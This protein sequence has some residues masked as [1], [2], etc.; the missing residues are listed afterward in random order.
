MHIDTF[1][2][3]EGTVIPSTVSVVDVLGYY[4]PNDG[5]GG[6]YTEHA[7]E[8]SHT[9]KFQADDLRWF[10]L[11]PD[12][13]FR[14]EQFG[15]KGDGTTDDTAAI[16]A[17]LDAVDMIT[18]G[19]RTY[20]I[21]EALEVSIGQSIVGQGPDITRVKRLTYDL[22]AS[23]PHHGF[24]CN[25]DNITLRGFTYDGNR[26]GDGGVA[27][28]RC[29]AIVIQG[30]D[31]L[32]ED[33]WCE[34]ATGYGQWAASET[35]PVSGAHIRCRVWNANVA[36]EQTG[37]DEISIIDCEG[38]VAPRDGGSEI[39]FG[40]DALVHPYG[41]I[42]SLTVARFKGTG[43]TTGFAPLCNT[44]DLLHISLINCDFDMTGAGN[45]VNCVAEG[46]FKILNLQ[47]IGCRFKAPGAQ[48]GSVAAFRGVEGSAIGCDF[49]GKGI[50]VY[51]G[52]GAKMNFTEC[53]ASA[54]EE[55]PNFAFGI[56]VED[57]GV[58]DWNG[59]LLAAEGPLGKEVPCQGSVRVSGMTRLVKITAGTSE[60]SPL[61]GPM[62]G[63][64][65]SGLTAAEFVTGVFKVLN[66]DG[67]GRAW[68]T[69]NL[70]LGLSGRGVTYDMTFNSRAGA[71]AFAIPANTAT[72]RTF[73]AVEYNLLPGNYANDAAAAAGGVPVGRTY[74]NG[75]Q[76]M[77][78]AA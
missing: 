2:T 50:A 15:A 65:V 74:R 12:Q 75:S 77:V 48:T 62:I 18:L 43:E 69:N 47:M 73:G 66:V 16:Q 67:A 8:P 28:D 11:A 25:G 6:Q 22:D 57:T 20:V 61:I 1:I 64:Y 35:E 10:G 38:H 34:N 29:H 78:R 31:Y 59:G 71:T 24:A 17:A 37:C 44:A 76:L 58:A 60:Y 26:A 56:K 49:E 7:T 55:A 33:V 27:N 32:I 72:L 51:I 68:T 4:E 36:F 39:S 46:S 5:G 9:A 70:G 3:A 13:E 40:T 23:G 14:V 19:A 42:D 30:L 63:G 21:G 45:G 54:E 52:S 53:R 41:G